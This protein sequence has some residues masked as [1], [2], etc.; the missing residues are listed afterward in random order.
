MSGS[1]KASGKERPV[2]GTWRTRAVILKSL[3]PLGS[4][5][6]SSADAIDFISIFSASMSVT[7]ERP[8]VRARRGEGIDCTAECGWCHA[9]R[10]T[11]ARLRAFSR[12]PV[13]GRDRDQ[14]STD[15]WRDQQA[16]FRYSVSRHFCDVL[17]CNAKW[18][19]VHASARD[20]QSISYLTNDRRLNDHR[21][22]AILQYLGAG[23]ILDTRG[24]SP[25][26]GMS[27]ES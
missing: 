14:Q 6:E 1:A 2:A 8:G 12:A 26:C 22:R 18:L 20:V 25:G 16:I 9:R 23:L 10:D 5:R 13:S 21:C 4:L 19:A 15:K 11:S 3:V 24:L 27:F 7:M 17:F